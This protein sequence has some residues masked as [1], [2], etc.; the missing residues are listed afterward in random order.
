MRKITETTDGKY[1]GLTV[2]DTQSTFILGGWEFTPTQTQQLGRGYV[3]YSNSSYV[4][5][6]REINNG[7]D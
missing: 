1:L 7:N 6:T 4:V 3:Q 2:D 5:L